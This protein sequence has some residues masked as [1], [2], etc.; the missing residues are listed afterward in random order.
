MFLKLTFDSLGVF[1]LPLLHRPDGL[2]EPG[3]IHSLVCDNL[4]LRD[5]CRRR[6]T[7]S[8]LT[9]QSTSENIQ[10]TLKYNQ[11]DVFSEPGAIHSLVCRTGRLLQELFC[12]WRLVESPVLSE[13][14]L[15]SSENILFSRNELP[16]ST[17]NTPF[18]K[19]E[20][21]GYKR[22]YAGLKREYAVLKR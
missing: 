20:Y 17:K 22:E 16:F 18:L 11:S 1:S 7:E 5:L 12:T 10:S 8:P 4:L 21:A 9:I 2:S 3:A 15:F 13:N 19:Q 14:M 6:L